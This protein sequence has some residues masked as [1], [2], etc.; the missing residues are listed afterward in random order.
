MLVNLSQFLFDSVHSEE[1]QA[2]NET[3]NFLRFFAQF[4]KQAITKEKLSRDPLNNLYISDTA[5]KATINC[6]FEGLTRKIPA[7]NYLRFV[8]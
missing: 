4:A 7:F 8:Y 5:L 6:L 2:F 3:N 1:R